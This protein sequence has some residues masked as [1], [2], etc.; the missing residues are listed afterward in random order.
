MTNFQ[1][2]RVVMPLVFA[3]D[4]FDYRER[5]GPTDSPLWQRVR[6]AW[7]ERPD[8][9]RGPTVEVTAPEE[10]RA[11]AEEVGLY[12]HFDAD[13]Y[14]KERR[15]GRDFLRR[16]TAALERAIERHAWS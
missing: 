7:V 15:A 6:R 16:M 13:S 9:G 8:K 12:D 14:A 4:V 1:P 5:G 3:R 2:Y 11:F 10:H